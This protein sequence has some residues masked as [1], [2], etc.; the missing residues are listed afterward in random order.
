MINF[1]D[2]IFHYL[3]TSNTITG[4]GH[5]ERNIKVLRRAMLQGYYMWLNPSRIPRHVSPGIVLSAKLSRISMKLLLLPQMIKN[6]FKLALPCLLIGLFLPH[7]GT[8]E[9]IDKVVAVVNDD[10]ITLSEVEE[11]ASRTY[12]SMAKELSGEKLLASLAEVREATLN[13]MIDR[14]LINQ[15]A[16]HYNASVTEEE[17]DTAYENT[18]K[19]MSLDPAEFR[20]KLAGS[21]LTEELYRKQLKD[22]ILQSKLI[23]YDVRAKIV[24]TEE[25][26]K[27]YY[28]E[29]HA[30]KADKGIYSLLQMGFTW[31]TDANDREKLT[32]AKDATRKRAEEVLELVRNGQDFKT[33]A[34]KHS[35]LP[36]A[37]DGGDIGILQL[38]D[39]ATAMRAAISP[40]EPGDLTDIIETSDGYQF[41]KV[42]SGE[43]NEK[44]SSTAFE[45][46]KEDIREKLYEE[47]MKAA[48]SEWVKKLKENAFIQK[49]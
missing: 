32:A 9:L 7:N 20:N 3:Q 41:Y 27:D 46:A 23:S 24:V 43:E 28:N 49:L 1:R 17:V 36:S 33:L 26:V 37:R 44:A 22:Q 25:M 40:L 10:I 12:Q 2:K 16:K 14:R 18:R 19:R 34:K 45:A 15:R 21:G 4:E 39:M 30:A 11:E 5:G 8:A 13:A 48:Y 6:L 35:D 29:H 38:D 31:K 47:K 42:L